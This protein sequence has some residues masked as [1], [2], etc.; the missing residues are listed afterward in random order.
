MG[1]LSHNR[2]PYL[3]DPQLKHT[4]IR[5]ISIVYCN[6]GMAW[7][8]IRPICSFTIIAILSNFFK[9]NKCLTENL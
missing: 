9:D 8:I 1:I 6:V 7:D 3:H 2:A 4:R 5:L